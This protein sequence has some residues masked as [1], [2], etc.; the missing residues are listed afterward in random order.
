MVEEIRSN[1]FLMKIRELLH[2]KAPRES[3]QITESELGPG[4]RTK[5][6]ND[7]PLG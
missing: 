3:S 6:E 1:L 5:L 7:D 2:E 4:I